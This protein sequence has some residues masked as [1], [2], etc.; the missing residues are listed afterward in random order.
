VAP[1]GKLKE[2]KKYFEKIVSEE[3]QVVGKV[4]TE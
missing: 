1:G 4:I 3:Q 2:I